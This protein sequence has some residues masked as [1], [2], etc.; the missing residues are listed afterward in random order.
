LMC[1]S[2]D[3]LSRGQLSSLRIMGSIAV[4]TECRG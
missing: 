1:E 2:S 4:I 3:P